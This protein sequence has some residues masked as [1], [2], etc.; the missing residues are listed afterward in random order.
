MRV[1]ALCEIPTKKGIIRQGE[2]VVIPETVLEKLKGKVEPIMSGSAKL[3][4]YWCKSTDFW[5]GGTPRHPKWICRKCH[6]PAP[7]AEVMV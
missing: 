6:P 1:K 7:G 5:R 2:I 4:C 3:I